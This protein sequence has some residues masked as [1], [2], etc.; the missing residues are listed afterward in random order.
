[1]QYM[2]QMAA[3]NSA[4]TGMV[5]WKSGACCV[6]ARPIHRSGTSCQHQTHLQ[7]FTHARHVPGSWRGKL[8]HSMI[9]S[10][11]GGATT[12]GA[13]RPLARSAAVCAEPQPVPPPAPA[14]A[15]APV[16]DPAFS[17]QAVGCPVLNA[18][19]SAA[20]ALSL[21]A[22]AVNVL[23]WVT[24]LANTSVPGCFKSAR[25]AYAHGRPPPAPPDANGS[26]CC[27]VRACDEPGLAKS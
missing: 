16:P 27:T 1:M 24:V 4:N 10:C 26:S 23:P 2:C 18:A 15:P 20:P 11:G 7:P 14:P 5:P 12:E 6:K 8:E 13:W 9:A 22:M 25:H 19:P 21:A 17:T 3:T